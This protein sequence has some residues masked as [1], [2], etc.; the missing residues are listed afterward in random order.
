MFRNQV[1]MSCERL[2]SWPLCAFSTTMKWMLPFKTI[3]N[4]YRISSVH[5]SELIGCM[6]YVPAKSKQHKKFMNNPFFLLCHLP[7]KLDFYFCPIFFLHSFH[8]Q[9]AVCKVISFQQPM[10][11]DKRC[12]NLCCTETQIKLHKKIYLQCVQVPKAVNTGT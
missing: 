2:K 5:S 12:T 3:I 11:S 8:Q 10:L 4:N 1:R 7:V 9:F 6:H